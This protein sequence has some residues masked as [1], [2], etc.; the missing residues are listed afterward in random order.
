VGRTGAI[1]WRERGAGGGARVAATAGVIGVG[2]FGA[3][4]YALPQYLFP[5]LEPLRVG[6]MAAALMYLGL[7]GRWVLG[8]EAPTAGGLRGL[9]LLVLVALALLSPGWSL[10]PASSRAASLELLKLAA[11]YVAVTGLVDRPDRL[12]R[13]LWALALAATVPAYHGVQ[14]SAAGLDL[15]DGYRT[16]W[17]GPFLDP[18]RLGMALVASALLL[19]GLRPRARGPVAQLGVGLLLALQVAAIL[20]TYS[21]GAALGLASGFVAYVLSGR[22]ARARSAVLVGAI[23]VALL[24]LAPERFWQR[25]ETITAYEED[26]SA[27]ARIHAWKTAG[28]VLAARPFTGVGQGAFL[29]AWASYAPPEAGPRAYVAHNLFLEVAAELGILAL[30][31]FLVFV[32]AGLRGAFRASARASPVREEGRAVFAALVGYLVCHLFA[33]HLL[34]FFL[35]LFLGLATAAERIARRGPW[36]DGAPP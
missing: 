5:A 32:G 31:A 16:R 1:A 33:G 2:V 21:R 26:A 28:H 4:L 19:V 11:A 15:L 10:D 13:V 14:N 7:V 36:P 12:R 23:A 34:G 27:L 24:A 25:T 18:N 3:T 29:A 9:A 30:A 22:G 17:L 20:F 35:F 8:G 6:V